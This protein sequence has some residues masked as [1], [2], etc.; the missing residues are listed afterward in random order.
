MK[1]TKKLT[2]KK[3]TISK[4]TEGNELKGGCVP[5]APPTTFSFKGCSS[6]I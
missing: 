5:T 2:L 4:L 6:R 3:Q 1:T